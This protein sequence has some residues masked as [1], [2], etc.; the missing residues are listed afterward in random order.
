MRLRQL[1]EPKAILSVIGVLTLIGVF[2]Y[3]GIPQARISLSS[4]QAQ[5]D[6]QA[7]QIQALFAVARGPRFVGYSIATVDG[8]AG[9][10]GLNAAC[11]QD[12]G[13]SSRACSSLEWANSPNAV[14]RNEGEVPA[15]IRPVI[16]S[17][18]ANSNPTFYDQT[19]IYLSFD[20]SGYGSC[21]GW[22]NPSSNRRGLVVNS[23]GLNLFPDGACNVSRP[24]TC[25]SV[26]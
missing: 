16:F 4:L 24:V 22:T 26:D 11:H 7:Q 21:N 23:I 14:H 19:G 5:V 3:P 10:P 2:I 8:S 18:T 1:K 20:N 13:A 25:C 9:F 6:A 12:F 15:W 17:V